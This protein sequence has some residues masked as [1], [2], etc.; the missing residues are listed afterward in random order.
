MA[1]VNF[2]EY[3]AFTTD[4]GIRFQKTENNKKKLVSE[5]DVPL[6][7]AALLKKNLGVTDEPKKTL[8]PATPPTPIEIT[9][10]NELA[11]DDFEDVPDANGFPA[12]SQPAQLNPIPEGVSGKEEQDKNHVDVDY[13]EAISIHSAPIE[14][15]AQ[16]LYERFG[17]Y[18]VY[19]GR[20]P[21]P[22]EVNPLTAEAMTNYE[23][24]VAYQ[25]AIRAEAKGLLS[26]DPTINKRALDNNLAAAA[27]VRQSYA[28][29]ANNLDEAQAQNNF[30]WRTSVEST[31]AGRPDTTLEHYVDEFGNTR[32]R[33]S[34]NGAT[35]RHV[36]DTEAGSDGQPV[37]EPKI[38]GQPIIRPNW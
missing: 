20:Y 9:D 21:Q 23:R 27:N 4:R 34:L 19:L 7:V 28:P 13:L 38:G 35:T 5:K 33:R 14:A 17:I 29:V 30:D 32:V 18:T 26:K 25:A 16:A 37:S 6:E 11:P 15:M 1:K 31:H 24:G 10:A 22:D 2:G 12:P 8:E 3:G 36:S